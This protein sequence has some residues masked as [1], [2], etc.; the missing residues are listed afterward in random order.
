[1]DK[2]AIVGKFNDEV[3]KSGPEATLPVNLSDFWLTTLLR[4]LEEVFENDDSP[5][6]DDD[7]GALSLPLLAVLHIVFAKNGG[8]EIS[9]SMDKLFEH[10]QD[11]RIELALEEVR[12]KTDVSPEPATLESIFTNRSVEVT[13]T[14]ND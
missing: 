2:D 10:M 9:I 11:Y 12:R 13:G 6:N 8:K 4:Y 3:I 5:E 14:E 1:M 7:S